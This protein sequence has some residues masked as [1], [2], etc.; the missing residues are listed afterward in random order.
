M[1]KAKKKPNGIAI[2]TD[3]DKMMKTKR[4]AAM[5]KIAV[6]VPDWNM[7]QIT[8]ILMNRKKNFSHLI[9]LVIANIMN[10]TDEDAAL[11][12]YVAASLNVEKYLIS[13]LA[14]NK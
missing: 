4:P 11:H 3:F 13:V 5:Q 9:L 7:P 1:N 14:F 6:R 10:A 8:Q 2:F 12:P